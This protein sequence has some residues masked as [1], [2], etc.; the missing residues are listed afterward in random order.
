M[1]KSTKALFDTLARIAESDKILSYKNEDEDIQFVL[2]PDPEGSAGKFMMFELA[3]L[4][5]TGPGNGDADDRIKEVIALDFDGY[6]DPDDS[7]TY[8]LD[9]WEVAR[10]NPSEEILSNMQDFINETVKYKICKCARNFIKDEKECCLYCHITATDDSFEKSECPICMDDALR[11]HTKTT[12]CCGKTVHAECMR[13][14][15][16]KSN[17]ETCPLCR[18]K[19]EKPKPRNVAPREDSEQQQIAMQIGG[20][21]I[22]QI[23]ARLRDQ[24]RGVD[25]SGDDDDDADDDADDDV[26][27][28]V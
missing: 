8:V 19:T 3:V 7:D 11:M 5:D 17:S 27:P 22:E 25:S 18:Q 4:T 6:H 15:L 14:W 23:N 10:K 2:R 9:S 28:D 12:T 20:A 16:L 24:N 13:T 26:S 1:I 21:I